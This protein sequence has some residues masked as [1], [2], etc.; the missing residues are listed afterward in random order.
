M[1]CL[2][3]GKQYFSPIDVENALVKIKEKDDTELY[4]S[5]ELM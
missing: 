4:F 2:L 5:T 3:V 1:S